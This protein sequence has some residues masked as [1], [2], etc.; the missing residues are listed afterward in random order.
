M[1]IILIFTV[2]A[3]LLSFFA[4]KAMLN[5]LRH[6]A[7]LDYPNNRSSHVI[8][9]PRG[10][11]IA[12][13]ATIAVTA[14]SWDMLFGQTNSNLSIL[15]C[16]TIGLSVISFIN[17]LSNLTASLRLTVHGIAVIVGLWSLDGRGAF[18][19]YLP[20]IADII[21]S[22][23]VWLWFINLYNFMDGIDGIVASETAFISF[24]IEGLTYLGLAPTS[25]LNL[26]VSIF[27][28]S[29]GFLMWN[30]HQAKIFLGDSGSIPLGFIIGYLLIANSKLGGA[31]LVAS[32][33][34]PL[35]F[36]V[37]SSVTLLRRVVQG[38]KITEAHRE[39]AYQLAARAGWKHDRVCLIILATNGILM[40]LSWGVLLINPLLSL[41][42]GIIVSLGC[43]FLF[44]KIGT[45][46]QKTA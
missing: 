14:I 37:D 24:G 41:V 35:V 7:L 19:A 2:L 28:A 9:T 46:A 4:T 38:N 34:L 3:A 23:V 8:P 12:V 1:S 36:V 20:Q 40:I 32:L 22:A 27:G 11:G 13:I 43:F 44:L 45:Q 31:G 30:W 25:L 39:H 15:L 42:F 6:S 18:A 21:L 29:L 5:I 10:G 17:D 26:S 33:I 16:A